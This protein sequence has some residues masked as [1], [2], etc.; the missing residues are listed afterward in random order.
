MEYEYTSENRIKKPHYYMYTPYHGRKFLD[1]YFD[2]RK[3]FKTSIVKD[4]DNKVSFSLVSLLVECKDSEVL[5]ENSDEMTISLLSLI[6]KLYSEK[7]TAGDVAALGAFIHRFEVKK[8]LGDYLDLKQAA[9]RCSKETSEVKRYILLALAC[10]LY[11]EKSKNL[12]Y[13][14]CLLKLNDLIISAKSEIQSSTAMALA[15][16][17]I[18]S[19]M[20]YTEQL[21]RQKVK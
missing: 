9:G 19:E 16:I 6:E 15:V 18:D 12:K 8:N 5:N 13:H 17:S 1:I 14:N 21:Y 11:Y 2:D 4:L 10:S 20:R 3:E 7:Y